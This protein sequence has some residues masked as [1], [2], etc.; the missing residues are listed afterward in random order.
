MAKGF[1]YILTNPT[2]P[3]LV[4][5][6]RATNLENRLQDLNRKVGKPYKVFSHLEVEDMETVEKLLHDAFDDYRINPRREFFEVEAARVASALELVNCT[7]VNAPTQQQTEPQPAQ[8][9][10]TQAQRQPNEQQPDPRIFP[11][12][13]FGIESG[14]ELTFARLD[15]N[16]K[17]IKAVL[18]EDGRILFKKPVSCDGKIIISKGEVMS[19]SK[20]A[21]KIINAE[22]R[23]KG[24]P[25]R[26]SAQGTVNWKYEDETLR[27]RQDRIERGG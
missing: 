9:Q 8:R 27:Q 25:L 1:V 4:K 20:A 24:L 16:S 5:I 3:G 12:A 10:A 2:M 19:L 22:K 18:Q 6:G 23:K 7:P 13:E 11:F 14:T 15:E 17:E 26:Q 21:L